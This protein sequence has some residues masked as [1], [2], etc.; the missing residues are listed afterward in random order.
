MPTYYSASKNLLFNVAPKVVM[1]SL[2]YNSGS[3]QLHRG[4]EN[5]ITQF[6][7]L[8]AMES[9]ISVT[10]VRQLVATERLCYT[11]SYLFAR[12]VTSRDALNNV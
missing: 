5:E 4:A 2:A 6:G 1:D 3:S 10:W 9:N 11:E 7:T 8:T 12:P